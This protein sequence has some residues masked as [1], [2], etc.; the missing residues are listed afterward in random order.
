METM[1]EP[2]LHIRG[3][4]KHVL[5]R[6]RLESGMAVQRVMARWPELVGEQVARHA[7]PV[8]VR[9]HRLHVAVDSPAWLQQLS[10]LKASILERIRQEEAEAQI[11]DVVLKIG[12]RPAPSDPREGDPELPPASL[13]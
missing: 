11:Q 6:H 4:L 9:F 8:G 7:W 1:A 13:G 5:R 12:T 3:I 10:F 2:F